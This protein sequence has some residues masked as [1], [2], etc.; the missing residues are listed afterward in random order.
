MLPPANAILVARQSAVAS[1]S[2]R[3]EA[4]QRNQTYAEITTRYKIIKNKS[5]I[6]ETTSIYKKLI[7][8]QQKHLLGI[9]ER[10]GGL[11]EDWE[12]VRGLGAS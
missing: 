2:E 7:A 9:C 6:Y 4:K 8:Y 11:W 10:T 5:V 1:L 3:P 12:F